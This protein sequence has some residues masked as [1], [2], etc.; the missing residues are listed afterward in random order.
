[1]DRRT[2]LKTAGYAAA[3]VVGGAVTYGYTSMSRPPA[4]TLTTTSAALT[5]A[6]TGGGIVVATWGGEWS[7]AV[8][9]LG[10]DFEKQTGSPVLVMVHPGPSSATLERIRAAWPNYYG[11]DV[12]QAGDFNGHLAMQA[13]YLAPLDDLASL[14]D[15]PP[16][17]IGKGK[18]GHTYYVGMYA[19]SEIF[20]YRPD[21]LSNPP[22]SLSDLENNSSYVGSVGIPHPSQACSFL[23]MCAYANGG[24]EFDIDPGFEAVKRLL[25][26]KVI[27]RVW[28]TDADARNALSSGEVLLSFAVAGNFV[29]LAKSGL[30]VKTIKG[31]SDAPIYYGTD[32]IAVIQNSLKVDVGKQFTD[33]L[34]RSDNATK[35]CN[36]VGMPPGNLKSTVVDPI[37]A[38][39]A[40]DSTLL[41]QKG[42]TADIDQYTA[43]IDNWVKRWDEEITPLL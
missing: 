9:S 30:N 12:Y 6:T 7:D 28:T 16:F 8:D 32:M 43:N 10:N 40:P 31:L 33:F 17:C 1:M 5:T 25:Q 21:E 39:L 22:A 15:Y 13:G 14:A 27:K 34:L 37:V 29:S 20:G 4:P 41:K 35:F 18:D 23:L 26:K 42:R 36:A 19:Y 24:S 3:A 2:F 11:V 38:D